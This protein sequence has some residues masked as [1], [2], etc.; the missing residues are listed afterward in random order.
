MP[1]GAL[2]L[3]RGTPDRGKTTLAGHIAFATAQPRGR[4][5]KLNKLIDYLARVPGCGPGFTTTCS[6]G[7]SR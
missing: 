4:E 2:M 7:S 1:S 6:K 3:M 5:E